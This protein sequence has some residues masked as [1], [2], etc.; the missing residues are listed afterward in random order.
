MRALCKLRDI[1]RL[2]RDFETFFQQKHDLSLNEGMLLCSL[3]QGKFSSSE[4]AEMLGLSAS[5][6]SKV[7]KAVENK[8]F[9]ERFLGK[10]DK[11][12]MYFILS[13][14]G[15]NKLKTIRKEESEIIKLLDQIVAATHLEG[16]VK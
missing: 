8:G 10:D 16:T 14:S 11:R 3:K 15:K 7:I 2:I 13:E 5:N 12:Q 4:L 6:T 1:N 9:V